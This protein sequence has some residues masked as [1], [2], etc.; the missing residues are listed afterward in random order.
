M[1]METTASEKIGE[2]E[3]WRHTARIVHT[4]VKMCAGDFNQ[5]ESL[6]QPEPNGNCL[7]WVLGHL[8]C[9][10]DNILP[11]LGQAPVMGAGRLERYDRGSAPLHEADEAIEM[12]ELLTAW[13]ESMKRM[14]AGLAGLTRER[15]N[16][17]A[18]FSPTNYSKE[19]MRSLLTT[20]FFHQAYH[21]GQAGILR[22]M[23]GK[24]G[25]IG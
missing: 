18:P 14:D 13:D 24:T 3:V 6:M 1:V 19:T 7:N 20:I 25:V 15:L 8:M 4:V 23:A 21:T 16:E 11:A 12:K 5:E 9:V 10:Y 22:R 2:V 17:P